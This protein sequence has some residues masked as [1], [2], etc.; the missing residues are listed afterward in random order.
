[1]QHVIMKVLNLLCAS[2]EPLELRVWDCVENC[3][4]VQKLVFGFISA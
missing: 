1:M 4:Y 3:L 2:E